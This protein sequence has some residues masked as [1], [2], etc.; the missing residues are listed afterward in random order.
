[1]TRFFTNAAL[2]LAIL[3]AAFAPAAHADND[4]D[5]Y[6]GADRGRYSTRDSRDN[7]RGGDDYRNDDHRGGYDRYDD[8][9]DRGRGDRYD[10]YDRDGGYGRG[11]YG[12]DSRWR[13]ALESRASSIRRRAFQ[14][15]RDGRLGRSQFE[16]VSDRLRRTDAILRTRQILTD[17]RFRSEMANLSDVERDLDDYSRRGR[18]GW[19]GRR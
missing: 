7:Y 17:S 2:S 9:Y 5:D 16:R 15:Q 10:R 14:L 11:G 13:Q 4:D 19:Y 6:R 18:G 1:M 12:S 3:T 8:R